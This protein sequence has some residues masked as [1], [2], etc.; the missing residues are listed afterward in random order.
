MYRKAIS[1]TNC[2]IS[3][4][5]GA[6]LRGLLATVGSYAPNYTRCLISVNAAQ[7]HRNV[8]SAHVQE[9]ALQNAP[10]AEE[11]VH[12]PLNQLTCYL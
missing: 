5:R 12:G 8:D 11:D 6:N 1:N 4:N 7:R 3:E 10:F 2:F 9:G